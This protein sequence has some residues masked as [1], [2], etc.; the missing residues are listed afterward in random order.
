MSIQ[1]LKKFGGLGVCDPQNCRG[2]RGTAPLF[3]ALCAKGGWLAPRAN[4]RH[5]A[6][7]QMRTPQR[8]AGLGGPGPLPR[9]DPAAAPGASWRDAAPGV[10]YASRPTGRS[11]PGGRRR[12]R[13]A[14][15]L[16]SYGGRGRPSTDRATGTGRQGLQGWRSHRRS[17]LRPCKCW[18]AV[19]R[20][21]RAQPPPWA[22]VWIEGGAC[23]DPRATDA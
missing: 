20:Q 9:P 18:R 4:N 23:A 14:P 11:V 21:A 22:A 17:R 12:P 5:G 7:L 1:K 16:P 8:K 3:A 13:D 19:L 2:C 10:R 15:G 6:A